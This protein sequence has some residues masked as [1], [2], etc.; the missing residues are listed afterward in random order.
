MTETSDWVHAGDGPYA[1]VMGED[2]LCEGTVSVEVQLS[3][4]ALIASAGLVLR[5]EDERDFALT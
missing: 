3:D 1:I 4:N 5:H 2:S